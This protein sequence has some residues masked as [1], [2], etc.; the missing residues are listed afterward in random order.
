MQQCR[1]FSKNVSVGSVKERQKR[2]SERQ[3]MEEQNKKATDPE[4][5]DGDN[6]D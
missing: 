5:L 2:L 6:V 1:D 4:T 3:L